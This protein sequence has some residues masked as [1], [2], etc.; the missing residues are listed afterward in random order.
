MR[1][2]FAALLIIVAAI[3]AQ[4]E[5]ITHSVGGGSVIAG[6]TPVTCSSGTTGVLFQSSGKVGCDSGFTYAGAG[7]QVKLNGGSATTPA[8]ALSPGNNTG[9]YSTGNF[10][11][12]AIL[13]TNIASFTGADLQAAS[14]I[15]WGWSNATK[16]SSPGT[17]TVQQGGADAA[18]PTAQV[19]RTQGVVAGTA[20]NVAGQN[21]TV[22][23]SPGVGSGAGGSFIVQTAPAHGSDTVQGTLTSVFSINSA[24]NMAATFNAATGTNAVCNTPGTLTAVTVQVWATGCAASSARF[25]EGIASISREK[26]LEDVLA[27]D[28]VSYRYKAEFNMGRDTHVGFTAEQVGSVDPQWITFEDDGVTPHAVKYNEMVPLLVA[29]I[30]QLKAEIDDLKRQRH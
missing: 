9:L 14:G 21:F 19:Y 22:E 16:W 2:L 23:V 13:G 27:F 29:A 6:V 12:F 8:L 7:G 5:L 1:W 4:G 11:Q 26:S 20:G 15:T 17:G 25:K 18:A 30:Q 28:A 24:G 10:I 3:A